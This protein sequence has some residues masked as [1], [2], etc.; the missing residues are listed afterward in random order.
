M[1][2][3]LMLQRIVFSDLADNVATLDHGEGVLTLNRGS[4]AE[5]LAWVLH[6][7]ACWLE[8]GRISHGR[9]RRHLRAVPTPA[10]LATDCSQ[11][12]S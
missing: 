7:V 5:S 8:T 1:S 6:D 9:R 11:A 10:L 3:E 4:S 12:Q 2:E